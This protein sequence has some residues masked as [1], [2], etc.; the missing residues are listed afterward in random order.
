MFSY[1]E[2]A[3]EKTVPG[4]DEMKDD[5]G[6]RQFLKST[7]VAAAISAGSAATAAAEEGKSERA[8]AIPIR[9]LG[10][11]KVK[12][13]IPGIRRCRATQVVGQFAFDRRSREVGSLCL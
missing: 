8:G 6:R 13:P 10:K 7:A 3:L 2:R 5:L 12:V 1:G 9:T 4:A 11:T